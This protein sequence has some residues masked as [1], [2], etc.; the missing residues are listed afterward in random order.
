MLRRVT[1]NNS[2]SSNITIAPTA[3]PTFAAPP[4]AN[5]TANITQ[6]ALDT[7]VY[8]YP[9]APPVPLDPWYVLAPEWYLPVAN[10]YV[11]PRA[12]N[13]VGKYHGR[14]IP[15]CAQQHVIPPT[16]LLPVPSPAPQPPPP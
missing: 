14:H 13:L 6:W 16:R 5:L 4:V 15:I 7:S 9:P 3:A 10:Y 12:G 11:V 8:A 1:S 2:N